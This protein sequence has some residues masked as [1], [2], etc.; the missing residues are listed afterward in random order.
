MWRLELDH[1]HHTGQIA[2]LARPVTLVAIDRTGADVLSPMDVARTHF[3]ARAIFRF[4][5]P[6]ARQRHHPLR[7]RAFMPFADP[8]DRQ[9]E[10]EDG[11]GIA[12]G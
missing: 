5:E 3:D 6:A 12:R 11:F 4:N 9:N 2:D 8:A 10:K 1:E 7:L